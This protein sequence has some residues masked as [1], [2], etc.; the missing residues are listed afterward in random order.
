MTAV[1]NQWSENPR[2]DLEHA[3]ELAQKALALDE[4]NSDA[5]SL[6]CQIDWMHSRYDQAVAD[7]K[8]AV[9]INPNYAQGY[10][11]LADVLVIY[12]K[13]EEAIRAAQKAIRLDPNGK[14][15]RLLDVGVAYVEMG[16]YEEAVPILKQPPGG[17]SQRIGKPTSACS[18]PT[19]SLAASRTRELRQ[20][21]SCESAHSSLVASVAAHQGRSQEQAVAET[22]CARPD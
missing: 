9:A 7:A 5:L 6:L 15:L 13:P 17:I 22:I 20:P 11:A 4:S 2:A 21:R 18:K 16:R 3:S 19:S 12:G 10:H 8:R 14:D 1:W